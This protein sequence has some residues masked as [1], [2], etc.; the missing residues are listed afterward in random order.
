MK[1]VFGILVGAAL[2]FSGA[3][4][5]FADGAALYSKCVACHGPNG[6][7]SNQMYPN[8]NGQHPKYLVKQMEDIASGKRK[9]SPMLAAMIPAVKSLS[10]EQMEEVADFLSK[11]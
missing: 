8:L 7:S 5:A 3:S 6:K 4:V 1:K 11:Q 2:M 10:H 9:N